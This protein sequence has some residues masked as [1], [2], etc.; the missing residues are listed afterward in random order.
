[1][2]FGKFYKV[3]HLHIYHQARKTIVMLFLEVQWLVRLP[4]FYPR[5]GK[6]RKPYFGRSLFCLRQT[7][8]LELLV[9]GVNRLVVSEK[10][11]CL[12]RGGGARA[13]LQTIT[14]PPAPHTF[15]IS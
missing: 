1:M 5:L 9:K 6:E 7:Q 15:P 12:C 11:G 13:Y 3:P 4:L 2:P 14:K 10:I 8:G